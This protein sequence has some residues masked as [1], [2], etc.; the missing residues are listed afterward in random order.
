MKTVLIASTLALLSFGA[1]ATDYVLTDVLAFNPFAPTGA[2]LCD[3]AGVI[4]CGG[5]ASSDG[6]NVTAD[7]MQFGLINANA[8]F[9][10]S[11]GSWN[12][13]VG[14]GVS[15]TKNS[16]TCVETA[17]TPCAGLLGTI[18]TGVPGP[19]NDVTVTEG[20]GILTITTSEEFAIANTV[21]GYIYSYAVIPVPAAVWLF[22]SGL[23]ALLAVRRRFTK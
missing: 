22:G 12:T 17:G 11:N 21:S 16:E 2:S 5:T 4:A 10:Y 6:T 9:N 7:G 8:T 19:L 3:D 1:N 23:L 20:G 13:T 18:Q 14:A 15:I